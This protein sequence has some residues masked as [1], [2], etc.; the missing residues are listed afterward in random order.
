MPHLKKSEVYQ[1]FTVEQ[2]ELLPAKTRETGPPVCPCFFLGYPEEKELSS[3]LGDASPQA[4]YL[5]RLQLACDQQ[6]QQN[7]WFL[8]L[9]Q[10]E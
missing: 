10:L 9:C 7:S 3:H 4:Q 8:P 6:L 1:K 5:P 2:T